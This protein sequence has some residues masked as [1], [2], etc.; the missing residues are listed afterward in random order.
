MPER[1]AR[2]PLPKITGSLHLE[3]KRCGRPKCRCRL[4][5]LH[6][7]YIYRHWR[8]GGRQKKVYVPMRRL[9]E[10]LLTIEELRTLAARPRQVVQRLRDCHNV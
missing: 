10:V 4:G 9:A 5:L 7:P 2:Q 3:F 8:E 6:G 1:K